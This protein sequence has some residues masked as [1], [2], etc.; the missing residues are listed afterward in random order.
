MSTWSVDAHRAART[1]AARN[2]A[3]RVSVVVPARNEARNLERVLPELPP[4]HE[5]ILVDGNSAD[6]TIATARRVMPDIKVVHQTRRGKG[7]ALAC[8]FVAATGDIVVMFDADGSA[9]AAEIERFVAALVD[10]ADFAKGTRFIAG[11]GSHDITPFRRA[12]NWFLNT[13]TNIFFRTRY[14]DLCY[15]YNAFWRDIVPVLDLLDT[16]LDDVDGPLIWGDGFEVETIINCRV[17]AA[18]LRIDEVP[19]I[20]RA[21]IFGESNL[22]AIRDGSRV[23]RTIFSERRRAVALR[24]GSRRPAQSANSTAP[25]PSQ[26]RASAPTTTHLP[27]PRKAQVIDLRDH[28]SE[29]AGESA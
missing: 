18:G 17:A 20:E 28:R 19:S 26:S 2:V 6:D 25:V 27:S 4:V 15:G 1:R 22:H 24:A 5:V 23:L 14:T 16:E 13:T 7:N 21:R 8:G 10:G 9:D 29:L 11:G 3:P 12:G